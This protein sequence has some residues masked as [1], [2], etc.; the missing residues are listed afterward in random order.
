VCWRKR[1]QIL[2]ADGDKDAIDRL[3]RP[4]ARRGRRHE[5]S[6]IGD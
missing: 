2:K 1:H 4:P 3:A 5:A 6:E